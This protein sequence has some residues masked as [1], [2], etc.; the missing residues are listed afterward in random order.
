MYGLPFA[1]HG[2]NVAFTDGHV[3][4]KRFETNAGYPA[5]CHTLPWTKTMDP[6]QRGAEKDSCHDVD[7]PV[8][9]GWST[10]NWY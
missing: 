1:N 8:G 4:W 7:N 5:L 2:G 6:E 3:E 9:Q 10:S